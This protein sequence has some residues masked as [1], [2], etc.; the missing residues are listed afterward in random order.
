MKLQETAPAHKRD[1]SLKEFK[2]HFLW[3]HLFQ[4][5]IFEMYFHFLLH[6]WVRVDC[7]PKSHQIYNRTR[8]NSFRKE[9]GFDAYAEDQLNVAVKNL[10]KFF[11][12]KW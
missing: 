2:S 11:L 6:I 3:V 10:A 1:M 7:R 12:K 9:T 8:S 4:T 5:E